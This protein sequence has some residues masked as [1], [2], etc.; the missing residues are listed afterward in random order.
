M[1]DSR[2]ED[3]IEA[4]LIKGGQSDFFNLFSNFWSVW[5]HKKVIFSHTHGKF[6]NWKVFCME[7]NIPGYGN[8]NYTYT[9]R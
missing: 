1:V 6:Q 8:H 4:Q 3:Q 5:Y 2:G 7:E 9:V